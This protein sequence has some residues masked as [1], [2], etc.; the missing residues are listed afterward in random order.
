MIVKQGKSIGVIHAMILM[1]ILLPLTGCSK[2]SEIGEPRDNIKAAEEVFSIGVNAYLW[3][4][5]LD[6]LSFMP[7][8][9]ADHESGTI[10]TDW[11]VNPNDSNERSKV[12]LYIIG[13]ELRADALKITVHRETLQ[14]GSWVEIAP[15]PEAAEQI[16]SAII[17][18]A[19]LLR[20]DN[21][22]I[23]N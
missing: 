15:R 17:I 19:R 3:R 1:L 9:E 20:R 2:R 14:N 21:A 22:P 5:S 10:F 4:A 16:N 23:T 8:L 7:M 12:D 6:T 13:K 11:A 18:Q